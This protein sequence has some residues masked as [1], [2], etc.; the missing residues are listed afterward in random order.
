MFLFIV[1][2]CVLTKKYRKERSF[3]S[4]AYSHRHKPFLP[5]KEEQKCF[6][7]IKK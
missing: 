3:L 7:Y 4:V 1:R 5:M 2:K 6:S